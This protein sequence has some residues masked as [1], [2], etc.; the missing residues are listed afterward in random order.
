MDA[1]H[2][3]TIHFMGSLIIHHTLAIPAKSNIIHEFIDAALII[4]GEV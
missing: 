3:K 4:N 2:I 1:F